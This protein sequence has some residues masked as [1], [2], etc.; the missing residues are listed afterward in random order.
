MMKN[1]LRGVTGFCLA[2]LIPG[3]VMADSGAAYQTVSRHVL[4]GSGHS[5]GF[6]A[7]DPEQPHL[8]IAR[9]ENGLTVFD[10][11][12]Q[13]ETITLADSV[14]A[15]AVAF[16]PSLHRAYVANMDGSL[17]VVDTRRLKVLKRIALDS[18]NL[19]NLVYLPAIKR[20]A[21]TSGR[22]G[23]E[24]TVYLFDPA[25]DTVTGSVKLPARKLDAPIGLADGR[26]IVPMRDEDQ[27][28]VL[29]GTDLQTVNYW[30]FAGCSRP[31]AVVADELSQQ[32]FVAC[33]GGQP[34]LLSASL[35]DGTLK[36][37][38]R[39]GRAVNALAFDPSHRQVLAPSGAD[40]EL[41]VFNNEPGGALQ[42]LASIGTQ[43]WAHNMVFDSINGRV[44]LFSMNY[45]QPLSADGATTGDP[46]FQ[47]D[48]FNIITLQQRP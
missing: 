24:S 34:T 42:P 4:K 47:P 25:Q 27:V 17:S 48:T 7:L 41:R 23:D 14:G 37:T 36:A 26:F 22:R 12:R 39:V 21:V 16:V 10:V 44:Y 6:A 11:N 1:T 15:N 20:V 45:S 30:K 32:L 8:Y 38:A 13:R 46:V 28:A 2:L 33:R 19:N 29:S 43:P 35:N 3:S 31:S 40:A 5:W 9:R 18:G